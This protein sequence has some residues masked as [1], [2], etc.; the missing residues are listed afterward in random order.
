MS[1]STP[2]TAPNTSP[3]IPVVVNGA[4]GKM[5]RAIV[6]AVA[7]ADDMTLVG[8]IDRNPQLL[9]QDIG[10]VVGVG[11]LEIPVLND[12]EATALE[13]EWIERTQPDSPRSPT[14]RYRLTGK[15]QRWLPADSQ[16]FYWYGVTA[17]GGAAG[18]R[19]L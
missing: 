2:S 3:K 16:L 7:E 13:D 12:L 4:L 17:A 1:D 8:A 19:V 11:P 6:K 15:G 5:G 9:G 14:Q 18:R 10:E